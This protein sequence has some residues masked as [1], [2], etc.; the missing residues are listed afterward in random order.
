MTILLYPKNSAF[1]HVVLFSVNVHEDLGGGDNLSVSFA[2][3]TVPHS[4]DYPSLP[5]EL[6]LDRRYPIQKW[7]SL[8]RYVNAAAADPNTFLPRHEVRDRAGLSELPWLYKGMPIR[9]KDPEALDIMITVNREVWLQRSRFNIKYDQ[10]TDPYRCGHISFTT[11][12]NSPDTLEELLEQHVRFLA[13]QKDYNTLRE[14][15]RIR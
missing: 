7:D 13:E 8:V 14:V 9:D 3:R 1:E 11:M 5:Y 15:L 12:F 10:K 2:G 4:M 6:R